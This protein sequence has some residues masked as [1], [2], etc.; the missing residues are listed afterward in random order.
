MKAAE[1][2]RDGLASTAPNKL[3]VLVSE[4]ESILAP[5]GKA[6][7]EYMIHCCGH[8]HIDMNWT[9]PLVETI[10]TAHDTYVSLDRLMELFPDLK[11]AQS[12]TYI[13]KL[14]Q[15]YCPEVWE[16]IKRRIDERL[17]QV[18]AGSWVEGDK[19]MA[20]GESLCRH[21]LYSKRWL[22]ENLGLP[23][24]TVKIDWLPDTFGHAWTL[25][26]IL[27][28]AGISCY[29]RC[30]P[31][32]G[33]WLTW[34]QGPDGSRV[35]SF[36]DKGWYNAEIT[37]ELITKHFID[38]E[39]ENGLKDFLWVYGVG[40]HG[41]GVTKGHLM[42]A[43]ELDS[44]PVFPNMKL[45]SIDS[46]FDAVE[47]V[48]E[49]LPVHDG[50][51]NTVFEACYTSQSKT[52]KVNRLAETV[53]PEAETVSI[54]ADAAVGFEYRA[55]QLRQA[56]EHA[57][58]NQFHDI[59][60]GSSGHDAMEE[61]ALRF[62]QIEGITGSIKMRALRKI[63]S[64]INTVSATG[65]APAS[66]TLDDYADNFGRGAGDVRIPGR[67]STLCS[68]TLDV[69][70]V[71]VFNTLPYPRSEMV[72]M[73]VWGRDWPQ[74]QLVVVDDQG[75]RTA[76]QVVGTSSDV[77]HKAIN[78]LF[79]A[80]DVPAL[81][82]R[83]FGVQ[84]A[85][86]PVKFNGISIPRPRKMENEF[87]SVEIDGPSGAI[88]HLVDKETGF[89][90]VPEGELI[91][92]LELYQEAPH[93]MTSWEIGQVTKKTVLTDGGVPIDET[94]LRDSREGDSLGMVFSVRQLQS[95][96]HRAAYRTLHM[97]N[98]SRVR[99]EVAL[100]EG[101]RSVDINIS[102]DWNELG[103]PEVGVP[104]LKL[105]LPI[106]IK[107]PE[108][109]CEIPFGS[110]KRPADGSEIP[111][112]RWVDLSND[113]HG[114]TLANDCKNG[115][116]AGG[117]TLRASLIRSTYDPDAYPEMGRH[118]IHFTLV[119]HSGPCDSA[120]AIRAAECLNLPMSVAG[121]GVHGG[122]LPTSKS[123]AE[124]L[125]PN[126]VL[127]SLK[128]AEDSDA[129]IVRV[130]EVEG[131]DTEARIRLRDL[132]GSKLRCIQTD[133]LEQPLAESSARLD[134]DVLVFSVQ[135]YGIATVMIGE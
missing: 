49:N 37:A 21:A 116:S 89:D 114:V 78:V 119:P 19:N 104:V 28:R 87:L 74:D 65:C 14:M 117:N 27:T 135:A 102:A 58:F 43:R 61:A 107:Q 126:V 121:T 25:P 129:L 45:S 12:Q 32:K 3:P 77:G 82:Y 108:F 5:I 39:K 64:Q 90:W 125:T 8:A 99:L 31:E 80:R 120:A 115:F 36:R 22:R 59:L 69:E 47:P 86:E 94:D 72:V 73:K 100:S 57:L 85:P 103:N 44:W 71:V 134:G 50:D 10:A 81:G 20:S 101:C 16:M 91:G 24:D 26:S 113:E 127:A 133:L 48:A 105:A 56:W 13:Y 92:V 60:A 4:A 128:K 132:I 38:Y 52:K 111:A 53:I 15:D 1:L 42:A 110:Q 70:P 95:G 55:E 88:K 35:L 123:F 33:P 83:T 96:P 84:V 62:Q 97:V 76:G 68:G 29:Y 23:F 6:A 40:D 106:N 18:A 118:D 11:F 131:K 67:V 112:L 2:V 54:V 130:Y 63:A 122:L 30:R 79:P 98:G 124:V 75:N 109:V 51:F 9:W 7:K 17:W 93:I 41:G 46:Y 66:K 34:W